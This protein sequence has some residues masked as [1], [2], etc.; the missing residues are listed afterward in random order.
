MVT[1]IVTAYA[2][3][4]TDAEA[5]AAGARHVVTRPVHFPGLLTL[6]EEALAQPN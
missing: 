6:V 5:H 1:M 2:G 4:S 3:N